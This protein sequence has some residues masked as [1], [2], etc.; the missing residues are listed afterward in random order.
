MGAAGRGRQHAVPHGSAV[1]LRR[2]DGIDL[3]GLCP[4]FASH[5]Q[6]SA[7]TTAF[8]PAAFAWLREINAAYAP[9]DVFRGNVTVPPATEG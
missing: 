7:S 6:D 1:D 3:D 8:P 4:G 5:N 9:Y 2:W